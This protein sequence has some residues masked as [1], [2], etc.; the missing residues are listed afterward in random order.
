LL[1]L[2]LGVCLPPARKDAGGAPTRPPLSPPSPRRKPNQH[3]LYSVPVTRPVL[4]SRL[5]ICLAGQF[6]WLHLPSQRY[7][8]LPL[9]SLS[10]SLLLV[11]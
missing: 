4:L 9:L 1:L 5:T 6:C 8:Y 10:L 3:T 2:L 7:P 11:L